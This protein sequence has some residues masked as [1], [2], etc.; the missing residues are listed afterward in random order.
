MS[1][2]LRS[3]ATAILAGTLLV[4]PLAGCSSSSYTCNSS[5]CNVSL[6]GKGADVEISDGVKVELHE[7]TDGTARITLG[8]AGEVSCTQGQ[9]I[10]LNDAKVTCNE[11]GN[12][13]VKLRIDYI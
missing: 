4:V 6:S 10:E 8:K 13:K 7:A 3:A 9:V 11:V 5:G 12:N 2:R 1:T